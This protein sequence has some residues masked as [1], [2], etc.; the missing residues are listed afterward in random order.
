MAGHRLRI[1]L[2][3][4]LYITIELIATYIQAHAKV[5]IKVS[6]A[7]RR[8]LHA[9][10]AKA[11][12]FTGRYLIAQS[13]KQAPSVTEPIRVQHTDTRQQRTLRNT[14]VI[15][16]ANPRIH[17]RIPRPVRPIG[18]EEIMQVQQRIAIQCDV[19]T[20]PAVLARLINQNKYDGGL[21]AN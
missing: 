3:L 16:D 18:P 9:S 1:S 10:G 20:L 4:R 19:S 14:E 2:P 21:Q 7:T 13:A 11:H 12:T 8:H 6:I 17:T 15:V 5:Y